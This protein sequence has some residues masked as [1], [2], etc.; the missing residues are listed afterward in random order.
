MDYTVEKKNDNTWI[1]A[2]GNFRMFLL[3]GEEKALLIDS[4]LSLRN[5]RK[6]AA[7][8]TDLPLELL[9]THADPDHIGANGEF[10]FCYMHPDEEENYRRAGCR[11][12]NEEFESFYMHPADE[13]HYRRSGKSG[14]VIPVRDGD[15]IDL[16][17]R[18]LVIYHIPGHTPGSVAVLDR[19]GRFLISGDPIQRNGDIFMYSHGRDLNAY[20]KGMEHLKE[21]LSEFD[22]IWPSHAD[23]PLTPDYIETIEQSAKDILSGKL[24][25]VESDMMGNR[26]MKYDTG[27]TVFL[28]DR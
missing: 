12:S 28:C 13:S 9:N 1:I 10:D 27:Y 7:G 24:K 21:H 25:G 11:G 26:V 22:E 14:K 8:F 2:E 18:K 4:G 6:I 15:E 20:I 16:G 23:L 17:N 19:A 5:V 3:A